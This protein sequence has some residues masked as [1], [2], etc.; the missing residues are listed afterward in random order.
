MKTNNK[1][2]CLLIYGGGLCDMANVFMRTFADVL[3]RTELFG[4]VFVGFYSFEAMLNEKFIKEWGDELRDEAEKSLAGYFGTC[5]DIFL[6]LPKHKKNRDKAISVLKAANIEW[7]FVGGGDGSSRQCA[8]IA[9]DFESEGIHI[10]FVMPC[11][12]DGIEGSR[13]IGLKPAVRVSCRIIEQLCATALCTRTGLKAPGLIVEL[14]GRNRDDILANVLQEIREG[15]CRVSEKEH[16][17]VI[18]IPANYDWSISRFI[19]AVNKQTMVQT[20]ILVLYSEGAKTSKS[21]LKDIMLRK[22]RTYEVG[23]LSQVNSMTND[24]DIEELETMLQRAYGSMVNAIKLG[25]SFC[26]AYNHTVTVEDIG[27]YAR[28][29][30]REGQNPTLS[31][32]LESTLKDYIP[33]PMKKK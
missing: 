1:A 5:R 8:E 12:I 13:S 22:V 4:K 18:A 27:Y 32:S 16:T 24:S 3:T 20:P 23:H 31:K 26:L 21:T 11:T 30:P 25:K 17:A 14:Q 2:N 19:E 15:N 9:E 6:D 7:V 28:L 10:A 33:A 29:N